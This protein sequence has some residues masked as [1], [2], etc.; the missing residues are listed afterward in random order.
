MK[1]G[2]RQLP[3]PALSG[4]TVPDWVA[5]PSIDLKPQSSARA[6][7]PASPAPDDVHG[8]AAAQIAVRVR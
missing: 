4:N 2:D 3:Q 8:T 1:Y 5:P 6:F 7:V